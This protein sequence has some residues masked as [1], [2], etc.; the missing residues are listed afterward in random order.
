M[1]KDATSGLTAE[2]MRENGR[3]TTCTVKVSTP[4]KMG[5]STKASILMIGN[6]ALEFIPG[7]M[8]ASMRAIGIMVSSTAKV[9]TDNQTEWSD[10]AVGRTAKELPG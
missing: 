4:G 8:A 10:V 3:I 1:E 9:S 6:T 7:K 5:E 2:D